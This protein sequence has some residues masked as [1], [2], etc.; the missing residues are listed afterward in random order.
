MPSERPQHQGEEWGL[1]GDG[2]QTKNQ[3]L[4]DANKAYSAV[5]K[6]KA[7]LS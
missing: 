4:G 3:C 2:P 1:S 6:R 5:R 7:I